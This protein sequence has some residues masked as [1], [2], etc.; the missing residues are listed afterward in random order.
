[1]PIREDGVIWLLFP[2]LSFTPKDMGGKGKG[3]I[4]SQL[5]HEDERLERYLDVWKWFRHDTTSNF[6]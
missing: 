5:F 3:G 4:L 2:E 1:M 6:R